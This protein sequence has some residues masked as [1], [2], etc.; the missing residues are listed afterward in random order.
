M[1]YQLRP[2]TGSH[3]DL[4]QVLRHD[5]HSRAVRI[6]LMTTRPCS[7]V[8]AFCTDSAEREMTCMVGLPCVSD[9]ISTAL[10]TDCSQQT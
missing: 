1:T 3:C 4:I 5:I 10:V 9:L 7:G 8:A 2:R 6:A